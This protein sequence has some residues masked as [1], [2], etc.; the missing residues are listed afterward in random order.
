MMKVY[1][2]L[3]MFVNL[4]YPYNKNVQQIYKYKRFTQR[5][6]VISQYLWIYDKNLLQYYKTNATRM[7]IRNLRISRPRVL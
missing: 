6:D 5:F 7:H 2:L 4:Q 3:E 1:T